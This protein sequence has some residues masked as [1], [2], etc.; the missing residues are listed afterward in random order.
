M[1]SRVYASG[2][3]GERD[4]ARLAMTAACGLG[5]VTTGLFL[6]MLA[7]TGGMPSSCDFAS[8]WA[9]GQQLVHHANPYDPSVMGKLEHAAG[10]V[11][12]G[13]SYMRN[14]PWALPL[15]LP[16]G[17]FSAHAAVLPWSLAVLGVLALSM[18]T[19]RRPLRLSGAPLQALGYC[20][21]PALQ[22]VLIGQTSLLLLLGLAL[23]LRL[24]RTRPFLAG[25]G[26]WMCT[27]KPH[28]FLPFGVV[29]LAWILISRSYKIVAG[30][31]AAGA[32]SCLLTV[33]IDPAA[34]SQYLHWARS[35]GI[36]N[37]PFPCLGVLFRNLI[38]PGAEWLVFV[39]C[40]AGCGWALWFFWS[41]RESWD[42]LEHGS[43]LMLVSLFVA[44]YCFVFDQCLA[45]PA[46]LYAASRVSSPRLLTT[47][48]GFY[49]LL[50][51]QPWFH[52]GAKAFFYSQ[53]WQAPAW[54][55]WYVLARASERKASHAAPLPVAAEI[56]TVG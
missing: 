15:T 5:V 7:R 1:A 20:F 32:A 35:S 37:E 52:L 45:I 23:F 19:L 11:G 13:S 48:A 28:L 25:A 39:P 36:A 9:T 12:K 47:L 27:L 44:P 18:V 54:L 10:F 34:F 38:D 49:L 4:G 30:A 55:A 8:Y 26:L 31:V 21:P 51:I 24:H 33:W 2:K 40:V 53:L 29:L 22:C 6:V 17:L 42:W 3:G 16:L 50:E 41:R 56:V 46:L 14:P 43:L